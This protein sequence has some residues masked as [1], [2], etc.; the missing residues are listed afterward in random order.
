MK[1][2]SLILAIVI[3]LCTDVI[4]LIMA[5]NNRAGQPF[6]IIELTE[7]ELAL[8]SMGQD[9]SGVAVSLKW[10]RQE[11]P[12]YFDRS[13]MEALGFNFAVP[14]GR[15]G[16]DILLSPRPAYAALEYEGDAWRQW[17]RRAEEEKQT[18]RASR[19]IQS[20]ATRLFPVDVANNPFELRSRYPDQKRY[21]IAA[22]AVQARIQNIADPKSG[23]VLTDRCVGLVS[24]IDPTDI[25]V[26]LPY[27]RLLS[28]LKPE[29]EDEPRY[30]IKLAYGRNL[31]PWVVE[32]K[33]NRNPVR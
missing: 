27:A 4:A 32:V 6:E 13:K 29:P 26:P 12:A 23:D 19:P 22:V 8:Q 2:W 5:T 1:R 11:E 31:E 17:V 7:R 30:T 25:N 9:N 28:S 18:G 21:L 33:L 15:T 16:R 14:K 24:G 3:L 20:F 10:H